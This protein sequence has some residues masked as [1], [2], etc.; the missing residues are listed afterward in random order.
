VSGWASAQRVLGI[1]LDAMGDLLMTTP[2]LRALAHARPDRR[3]T[4]LS[5]PSGA[6]AARLMPFIHETI[7]YEAPWMKSTAERASSAYDLAM[8]DR[9]RAGHFEAAVI[10]TVYTQS[11]LPAALLCMLAD[12]PL[13]AAHC[14][15]N[16]YQLLTH[17]AKE[18]D[19]ETHVRHEVRRQLDLVESVVGSTGADDRMSIAIGSGA[20]QRVD[21]LLSGR[22]D[23]PSRW[24]ALHPGGSAPS[25]RYPLDSF[26]VVA[27]QLIREFGYQIVWTGSKEETALID[28]VQRMVQEPSYSLAGKMNV[29]EL[30]ALIARAP[31]LIS[32]NTSAVHLASAVGTPVVDLYALTNPQHTPWRVP[33]RV[34]FDDVPCRF[35]YKSVCPEGHHRCL[36]GV[37]PENVVKAAIELAEERK[38]RDRSQMPDRSSLPRQFV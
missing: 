15:E 11:A 28:E 14:R 9:L 24:I 37:A 34:L 26:A 33:C 19:T 7:V 6:E 38:Q 32:N 1:R 12:I 13:R 8:V 16:P 17:W 31:L 4:L 30:A 25:R 10:F 23:R 18:R 2:A 20:F 3:L 22:I 35:C 21:G 5:S 29:E 27:R 36:R